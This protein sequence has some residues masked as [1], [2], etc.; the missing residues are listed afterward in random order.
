VL[1]TLLAVAAAAL[2]VAPASAAS[3]QPAPVDLVG[4]DFHLINGYSHRCLA[5]GAGTAV[6]QKQCSSSVSDRWRLAPAGVPN[7]FQIRHVGTEECLTAG[8]S[9]GGCAESPARRWRLLDSDDPYAQ[10]QNLGTGTCLTAG[11]AGDVTQGRCDDLRSR[12][13]TVRVVSIPFLS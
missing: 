6:V 12:R 1:K 5:Q 9:L 3:A 7:V 4:L 10:V 13:W 2:V 11:A 8:P